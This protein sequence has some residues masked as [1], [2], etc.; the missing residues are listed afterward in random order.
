MAAPRSP[1]ANRGGNALRHWVRFVWLL[2]PLGLLVWA[3]SGFY[4]VGTDEAGV[5]TR[6]GRVLPDRVE[7]GLHYALPWPV[8][9]VYTP[10]TTDVKN[11]NVGFTTKGEKWAERR[12]SDMLTGDENI[13]K[14]MMVVQYKIRDPEANLFGVEDPHWLVERTV[15]SAVNR[16][17]AEREVDAVLTTA[18]DEVQVE[19]IRIAQELL[20]AYGAG[21]WLLGGNLQVVDPPV[22]VM[23]AFKD[24]ASAK[25]DKERLVD[26]AR[27]YASRILPEARGRAQQVV[28]KAKGISADRL[29][30][31]RGDTDRFLSLFEEYRH[32]KEI[33]RRR[34]YVESMERVFS[35][36]DVVVLDRPAG[37]EAGAGAS[38]ITIVDR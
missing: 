29:S 27:E 32:A 11:I 20:D 38:R 17:V 15:E 8:D 31:A 24:V 2:A 36:M 33:T 7:P 14:I 21:I 26:E 4:T 9:R 34:L 1:D 13:L 18:K 12:R 30:R 37:A 23:E 22:P 19:A 3:A 28:S 35:K 6:F 16:L 10:R 25:K 5:V